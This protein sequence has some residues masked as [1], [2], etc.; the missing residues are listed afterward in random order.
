MGDGGYDIVA[1]AQQ[2]HA[3]WADFGLAQLDAAVD[4]LT[5][6]GQRP[7]SHRNLSRNSISRAGK[8]RI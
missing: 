4:E 5:H 8:N 3:R 6:N 7:L 1:R 2:I